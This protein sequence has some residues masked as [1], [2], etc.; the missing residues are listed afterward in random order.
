MNGASAHRAAGGRVGES[1][2]FKRIEVVA[3]HLKHVESHDEKISKSRRGI[4]I[5]SALGFGK[6]GEEPDLHNLYFVIQG[7]VNFLHAKAR[8]I[9]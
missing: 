6:H 8:E 9:P 2:D 5:S 3:N 1:K 7:A 4:P